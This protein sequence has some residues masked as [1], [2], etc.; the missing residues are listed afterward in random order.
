MKKVLYFVLLL[1][2]TAFVSCE[3]EEIGGTE[4]EATAGDW[5][6]TVDGA[7]ENGNVVEGF[8]DLYGLG[9]IHM[10]TLNTAANTPNEMIVTDLQ[11][12]WDFKVKVSCD[13]QGLTF[14]TNT[15]ENNNLVEDYED[16]NVSITGGKI[17][18]Q[19][20]RQNNGSPA[21]SIV[22]YVTFSDDLTDEGVP[23][24][25]AYGFAKYKVSGIRYSGLV[26]ND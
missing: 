20:G 12:F 19:A 5:Y 3:K 7:D 14:Q 9:R 6:V 26:E 17:I 23:T 4:T 11:N 13:Q 18:P 15:S 8:E 21:D 16:I 10:L 24:P 1:L 22:F 25:Q 2:S